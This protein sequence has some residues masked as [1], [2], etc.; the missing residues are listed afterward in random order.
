MR[1]PYEPYIPQDLG[2]LTDLLSL[3]ML[4]APTFADTSGYFP[5]RN[6]DTEFLAL[7]EGLKIN[8]RRLGEGRYEKLVELSNQMRAFFESDPG[9]TTGGTL[10]GR[11]LIVDM[12]DLIRARGS[13]SQR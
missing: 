3:M 10:K 4:T 9:K 1:P 13:K 2:D 7:N 8:K 12:M 11:E 6:I 5:G